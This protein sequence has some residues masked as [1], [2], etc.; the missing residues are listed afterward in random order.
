LAV[1][2]RA[3]LEQLY[4]IL[5]IED[6]YSFIEPLFL[7]L[8]SVEN[9]WKKPLTFPQAPKKLAILDENCD[10]RQEDWKRRTENGSNFKKLE[11][12]NF[13]LF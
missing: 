11:E 1:N 2:R 10:R 9:L 3:W 5:A 13:G 8:L 7:F 4:C 12:G 6:F